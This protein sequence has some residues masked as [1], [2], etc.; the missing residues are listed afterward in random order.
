MEI[1]RKTLIVVDEAGMLSTRQAHH[2]LQLSANAMGRRWCSRATQGN[3][4]RSRRGR[5]LRLIRDVAGSVRVDRIRRQK[6][7]LEDVLVHVHR[8]DAGT[9]ALPGRADQPAASAIR[10][11]RRLRG[12]GAQTFVFTPWQV[13]VSEAL[14]DGE[15]EQ[16]I[17]A[18]RLRGR[19]HL[20]H[21]EEKTLTRLVD[22]WERHV[23]RGAGYLG[24]GSGA[25][26]GRGTRTLLA[27]AAA[28]ARAHTPEA[29]RA[30]IEV[31]RDL[32]GRLTEPLEI[33]VGDRLRIGATQWEKQ[34]FNGTV[35]TVEEL[36][37]RHGERAEDRAAQRDEEQG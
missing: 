30:V 32:D 22:D 26:P 37:V 8:G 23:K 14:R 1:G 21:D 29:K 11:P 33:A 28:G 15:A 2:I 17:E 34:L 10:D 9:G 24:G 13:S 4:S 35:V 5:G 16:A 25:H 20:R 18:W 36:E 19:L 3:S 27:D 31:S 6:A 12:D 7:D